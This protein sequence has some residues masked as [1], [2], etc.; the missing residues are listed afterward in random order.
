M[1][2][3]GEKD[4]IVTKNYTGFFMRMALAVCL[5][6]V[7]FT[8]SA[9]SPAPESVTSAEGGVDRASFNFDESL[10]SVEEASITVEVA[11]TGFALD[12]TYDSLKD[13]GLISDKIYSYLYCSDYGEWH[14]VFL[15]DFV[16]LDDL[17]DSLGMSS[18]WTKGAS[19]WLDSGTPYLPSD[20]EDVTDQR[21]FYGN[22]TAYEA[23]LPATSAAPAGIGF[24]Y[25][26]VTIPSGKT[27]ADML[28]DDLFWM[29]GPYFAIGLD[30]ET[31]FGDWED[32]SVYRFVQQVST[33][34]ILPSGDADLTLDVDVSGDD[35]EHVNIETALTTD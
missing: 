29:D 16:T 35:G 2:F 5:L 24:R 22:T 19:L 18:A 15:T 9:C 10:D 32:T 8:F 14:V 4:S 13:S 3:D 11:Q 25:A 20:F 28:T 12:A 27:A 6:V 21:S 17:F 34:R 7:Y 23:T 26:D 31:L 33:I 1:A 30:D